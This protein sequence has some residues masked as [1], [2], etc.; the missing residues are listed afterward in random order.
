M[1]GIKVIGFFIVLILVMATVTIAVVDPQGG[2]AAVKEVGQAAM[3][4][5][6]Q[7]P[8]AEVVEPVAEAASAAV[9]T[10]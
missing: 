4:L 6:G 8:V 10:L 5:I 7:A 9:S 2:L 1:H 3:S